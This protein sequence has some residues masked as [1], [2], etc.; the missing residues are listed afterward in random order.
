MLKDARARRIRTGTDQA[1]T[2]W[3]ARD[4]LWGVHLVTASDAARDGVGLGEVD[5]FITSNSDPNR[6]DA[7]GSRE[8]Q[9][10]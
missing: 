1:P 4:A 10:P 3:F 8:S 7:P 5:R 6:V 2:T 9:A